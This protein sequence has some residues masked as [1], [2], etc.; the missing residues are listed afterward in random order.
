MINI[1]RL[2]GKDRALEPEQVSSTLSLALSVS[3]SPMVK[4][5]KKGNVYHPWF[6]F[7]LVLPDINCYYNVFI[8]QYSMVN[9]RKGAAIEVFLPL[10]TFR[11]LEFPLVEPP[12]PSYS[13]PES[14]ILRSNQKPF[15]IS[16]SPGLSSRP[17]PVSVSDP[18]STPRNC[19]LLTNQQEPLPVDK[20]SVGRD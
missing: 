6:S 3:V 13:A 17:Q 11:L 7:F 16:Q 18:Q 5:S 19:L 8:I 9:N 4:V 1:W 14:F 20:S 15:L 10:T 12:S 2:G